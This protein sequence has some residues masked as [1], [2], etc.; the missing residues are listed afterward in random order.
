MAGAFFTQYTDAAGDIYL[1]GGTVSGGTGNILVDG[2]KLYDLETTT[3]VG[4]PG[5]V[6]ALQI[7]GNGQTTSG[8]LDPIYNVTAASVPTVVGLLPNN[9]LPVS[10]SVG[11][12]FCHISL[13]TFFNGGFGPANVGN[14][15]VGFCWG[16]YSVSR[17]Q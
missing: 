16:G 11:G 4:T 1:Q 15:R 10:G 12:K 14:I 3:W 17:D 8:I 5:M 7:T 6:L 13:G 2:F 9:T